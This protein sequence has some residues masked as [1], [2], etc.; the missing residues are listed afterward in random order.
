MRIAIAFAYGA[1]GEADP[2]SLRDKI[3]KGFAGRATVDPEKDWFFINWRGPAWKAPE[4][5][6]VWLVE[7]RWKRGQEGR[8]TADSDG[9]FEDDSG[10]LIEDL[11]REL[12]GNAVIDR[13]AVARSA[14]KL[15]YTYFLKPLRDSVKN[16]LPDPGLAVAQRPSG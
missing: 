9:T 4:T 15:A 14:I 3:I 16:G 5:D 8:P 1:G 13:D 11:R 10:A 12:C 2:T 7:R 6:L